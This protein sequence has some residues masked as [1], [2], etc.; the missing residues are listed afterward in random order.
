MKREQNI[1]QKIKRSKYTKGIIAL[2]M[3]LIICV[4][5]NYI[6]HIYNKT[7]IAKSV[8]NLLLIEDN[9]IGSVCKDV[10]L[11]SFSSNM[12]INE[13]VN[14]YSN[15]I[16]QS[17]E[18]NLLSET[19]SIIKSQ[20]VENKENLLQED[21]SSK[22]LTE[23]E[24]NSSSSNEDILDSDSSDENELG[25]SSSN[26]NMS[27]N[28]SSNE[29]TSNSS[30]L[31]NESSLV[32]NESFA[33]KLKVSKQTDQL[34]VVKGKRRS[35]TIVFLHKKENGLWKNILSITGVKIS[36]NGI[37][38]DNQEGY[39][40]IPEGVYSLGTA[41]GT[42][43]NPGISLP[44]KQINNNDC[45]KYEYGIELNYNASLNSELGV[46]ILLCSSEES[47]VYGCV[48]VPKDDL[49][50]IMKNINSNCLIVIAEGDNIY[51]Y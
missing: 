50:S 33:A 38:T 3:V 28:N 4:S 42:N 24:I 25:D 22:S 49:L 14:K 35:R 39:G 7:K 47:G 31:P 2:I 19:N 17:E 32:S 29:S 34:I 15:D 23:D 27:S 11:T 13:N 21:S 45:S 41:F 37:A 6:F 36:A 10:H 26:E 30:N 18:S 46:R 8:N 5:A 16:V 43:I 20:E 1:L 51:N 48:T 44:Y 40:K 9:M 12:D